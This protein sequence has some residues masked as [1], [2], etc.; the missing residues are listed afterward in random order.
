MNGLY[1]VH[2]AVAEALRRSEEH[3]V[4]TVVVRRSGHTG[5]L[6]VLLPIASVAN[7]M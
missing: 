7:T 3:G 5:C 4:A 6:Q 1:L 2:E